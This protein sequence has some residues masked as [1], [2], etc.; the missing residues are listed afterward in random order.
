[1]RLEVPVDVH[2]TSLDVYYIILTP[3]EARFLI[4]SKRSLVRVSFSPSP[5]PPAS[6]HPHHPLPQPPPSAPPLAPPPKIP[7]PNIHRYYKSL[8][9]IETRFPISGE[10]GHVRL[11][12][13][14]CDAFRPSKKSSQSNIHFEKS[15][16]LFNV[17]AVI[18]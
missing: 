6:P 1:M 2:N 11:S 13:P 7:T 17:A 16:I 15:A 4:S 9:A 14:W 8:T 5:I 3:I 10:R 18:R 12:F